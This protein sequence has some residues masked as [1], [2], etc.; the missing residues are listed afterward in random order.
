MS[1]SVLVPK[2][3]TAAIILIIILAVPFIS[4]A[5]QIEEIEPQLKSTSAA[6]S[7]GSDTPSLWKR[8]MRS[9]GFGEEKSTASPEVAAAVQPTAAPQPAPAVT[10][11]KTEAVYSGTVDLADVE[12]MTAEKAELD[13]MVAEKAEQIRIAVEKKAAEERRAALEAEQARIAAEKVEQERLTTE[14]NE[15]IRIT[16]MKAEQDRLAAEQAELIRTAAERSERDRPAALKV[17]QN[18]S[19]AQN[20]AVENI[21]PDKAEPRDSRA[22]VSSGTIQKT[23]TPPASSPWKSFLSFF[24]LHDNRPAIPPL[25]VTSATAAPGQDYIVGP[26]DLLAVSVWRDDSLSRSVVVLPDGKIQ[27]PLI[28]ELVAGGKTVAQLKQEF[29]TRL[30]SFV[31]DADICVEVK[32][33]NSLFIY[34]IGKVNNP[35]R[36]MLVADTSILQALAMAGGLNPF[37]EKD[38]IKVFRQEKERTLVYSFRY[39]QVISGT[40]LD[41]NLLL[42][43]GDVIVVN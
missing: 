19:V 7:G 24:G 15:Q 34:I 22:P 40:H 2:I 23:A 12:K 18:L 9:L 20:I 36:Q 27:F 41:D 21:T 3:R 14:R 43:R 33:S 39:T 35:G 13:R 42:K 10:V 31:V 4:A 16:A 8:T 11:D 26:G 6:S 30:A 1:T 37:A 29:V 32:Q 17:E 25:E 28:G 5:D 38:E